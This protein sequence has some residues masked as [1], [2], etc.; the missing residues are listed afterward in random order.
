MAYSDDG[1]GPSLRC[2]SRETLEG[3]R[4]PDRHDISFLNVVSTTTVGR[5]PLADLRQAQPTESEAV[6]IDSD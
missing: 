2:G 1:G 5:S 4:G 6:M 3:R